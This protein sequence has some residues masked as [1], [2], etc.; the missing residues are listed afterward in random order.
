MAEIRNLR[1]ETLG[2]LAENT[3]RKPTPN[4]EK[5][6]GAIGYDLFFPTEAKSLGVVVAENRDYFD[7]YISVDVRP[8]LRDFI[9][10][11]LTVALRSRRLFLARSFRKSQPIQLR[12]IETANQTMQER[13]PDARVIILPISTSAQFDLAYFK[14]TGQVLFKGI[15][16]AGLDELSNGCFCSVG[17]YHPD[18]GLFVSAISRGIGYSFVGALSAVV[19]VNS[20]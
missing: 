13:L 7:K 6:L 20:K 2:L 11:V 8:E 9:P 3:F 1:Q 16:A 15:D 5:T 12:I 14:K 17:R 19:M 18:R 10:P 4:E